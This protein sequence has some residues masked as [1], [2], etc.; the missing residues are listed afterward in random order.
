MAESKLAF[1]AIGTDA[2]NENFVA[3]ID[4]DVR[5]EFRNYD[6]DYFDYVDPDDIEVDKYGKKYVVMKD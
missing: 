3:E 4:G 2:S 6:P 1:V 5:V